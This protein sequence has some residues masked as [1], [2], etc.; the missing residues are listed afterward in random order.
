VKFLDLRLLAYG[1]F[2]DAKLSF[3]PDPLG[4]H[5]IYGPNEAGKSTALR[6]VKGL[7]Y[8]IPRDTPDAHLHRTADLRIGAR[9]GGEDG[10]TLDVVRRKGNTNT[11]LDPSETPIDEALLKRLL[12][13]VGEEHFA[14]MFGLDHEG[15][16]RGAQALLAGKGHVGES[17]FEA[18]LG[19]VGLHEVLSGLRDEAEKLFT[20]N[21]RNKPLNEA[22]RR[23]GEA[24]KRSRDSA[25]S[26]E[27]WLKQKQAI[28]DAGKQRAGLEQ[29]LR[30]LTAKKARLLRARRALPL[31][32]KR[33]LVVSERT[34]LGEVVLLAEGAAEERRDALRVESE[35][36]RRIER[37]GEELKTL[38]ERRAQL[39]IPESLVAEAVRMKR[40]Q[41]RFGGY[42]TAGRDLPRVRNELRRADDEIAALV[43]QL[44]RASQAE[45]RVDAA[46]Q[47][48]VKKLALE[49]QGVA[50]ARDQASRAHDEARAGLAAAKSARESEP[51]AVDAGALRAA[52]ERVRKHG[53]VEAQLGRLA[54]ERA[55]L[56]AAADR[57]LAALGLWSGTLAQLPS[58]AV[59]SLETV[60]THEQ[61]LGAAARDG[62][63]LAKELERCSARRE[64]IA[65]DLDVLR[66]EGAPPTEDD[67]AAA[68]AARGEAWAAV[69]RGNASAAQLEAY[70]EKVA[71]ADALADRLRREAQRVAKLSQLLADE[72]AG[73]REAV[74][75]E[76]E[77]TRLEARRVAAESAWREAWQPA[78]IAP[79]SPAEMRA[80]LGR[81]A[82]L[83]AQAEQLE[84]LQRDESV[85]AGLRDR[86]A[87]ELADALPATSPETL[88]RRIERASLRVHELEV[89][90]ARRRERES[91]AGRA[92]REVEAAQR[93][94]AAREQAFA[95]WRAAW[96]EV[97]GALGLDGE[98][99]P[100]EA[101]AVLEL[102]ARLGAARERQRELVR[103]VDG[104][105]RDMKAYADEVA[106]LS[107]AHAPE[108]GGLAV[109]QQAERL[110][111]LY[112]KG[113]TDLELREVIDTHR[114]EK[115]GALTAERE[116]LEQAALR[117]AEL[118]RAARV[119]S[120][121]ALEAAE[122]RSQRA[123]ELDRQLREL[124]EQ[125]LGLAE[126]ADLAQLETEAQ[127]HAADDFDT[128]L[129]RLDEELDRLQADKEVVIHRIGSYE[130]GLEEWDKGSTAA[131]AAGEAQ[132]HLAKARDCVDRWLKVKLA[133]A[134]L[135][136]QI[137]QYRQRNQGPIL[138]RASELFRRLT[139]DGYGGLRSSFDEHD[140]PVLVCMKADGREVPVEGLS[141]GTRDQLYLSLRLATLER[142]ASA[143]EPMPLVVD[144]ILIH[145]DDHRAQASL[146]VLGELSQRMQVLFF[147]HH[148]RLLEL[149]RQAVPAMKEHRLP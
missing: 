27:T 30:E 112:Q 20:A 97:T 5:V 24:Q 31:V 106:Q 129:E 17:L 42:E 128:E 125:L 146:Q 104:M 38:E 113:R 74:R 139:L 148:A 70:E 75:L 51:G 135:G 33:R 126:G 34:Q 72:A 80:W 53:D 1:H 109:E 111:Q 60:A 39:K 19:G 4:L 67:L 68:R 18:G 123:H 142:H 85:Q 144:D 52:V 14:T 107:S 11:L 82:A 28:E 92:A 90:A 54:E 22:L 76:G 122:A 79:A 121:V 21:A 138:T 134:V 35:A 3:E 115:R 69:K 124:E 55:R 86:L 94:L 137:E 48:R 65:T 12:G 136:R 7:L 56:L 46:L 63:A 99:A 120:L 45:A 89:A 98:A 103:R 130:K 141:D 145:F 140:Q 50:A 102:H 2:R 9:L 44:G 8:G 10:A 57:K 100:E 43:G 127:A 61:A 49:A 15:L 114:E 95:T 66:R 105:E 73:A 13:G 93:E 25:L 81:H 108:L 32:A 87:A 62:E 143:H 23:F 64:Q 78:G 101:D 133:G 116:R 26:S 91:D 118:L 77:R 88:S 131:D 41:D 96:L 149:A 132:E 84:T 71:A 59:P 6:A 29:E 147:T 58:L 110:G 16:R 83:A 119:E 47:A 40:V 37:L 36:G 117:L